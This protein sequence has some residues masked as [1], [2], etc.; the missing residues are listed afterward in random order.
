MLEVCLNLDGSV[1]Q[2]MR[3]KSILK[4]AGA[5]YFADE[6][7]RINQVKDGGAAVF[8]TS[9]VFLNADEASELIHVLARDEERSDE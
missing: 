7:I 5:S 4:N 2:S 3:V 8:F 1:K 6:P 9:L